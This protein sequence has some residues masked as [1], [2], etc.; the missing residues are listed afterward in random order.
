M[1]A[2]F[3]LLSWPNSSKRFKCKQSPESEVQQFFLNGSVYA[4]TQ[5]A[6]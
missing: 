5:L 4:R 2:F 3:E 1:I 6:S